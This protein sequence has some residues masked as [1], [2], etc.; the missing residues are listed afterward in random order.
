MF[1]K[2]KFYQL[3]EKLLA[4]YVNQLLNIVFNTARQRFDSASDEYS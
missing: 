3:V 4:V 2:L 1:E